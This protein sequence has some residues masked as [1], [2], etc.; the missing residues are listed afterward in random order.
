MKRHLTLE[1]GYDD[2]D[3]VCVCV[4]W[5]RVRER[6]GDGK[7]SNEWMNVVKINTNWYLS[8]VFHLSYWNEGA[9]ISSSSSVGLTFNSPDLS[10]H[11][12]PTM[13]L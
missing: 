6:D 1:S 8:Y 10:T 7:G 2:D 3:I 13:S 9:R 4:C 12:N 5:D 11:T